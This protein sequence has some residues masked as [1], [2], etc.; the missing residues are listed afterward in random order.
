MCIMQ[1]SLVLVIS[2]RGRKMTELKRRKDS[3]NR[4]LKQNESQR[5]DGT[6]QYRWRD[7]LGNRFT[8]YAKT[9]QELREKEEQLTQAKYDGIKVEASKTTLND[10]Y[11][12]WVTLKR[13]LKDNTFQNYQY[14]Y[15][16]FV[17]ADF[18]KYKVTEIK[19]SDVRR[20]YNQLLDI[21]NVKVRTIEN[22]QTVLYQVFEL[23]IEE[24]YIRVNPSSN[25]LRELKRVHGDDSEKRKALTL[26]EQELFVKFLNEDKICER[27]KN[28][29][30]V[31]LNTGLRVGEL[32]GLRWEDVDFENN[33]ISVNHTLVYYNHRVNGCY[34]S[35]NTPKTKAG[36]RTVPM[37]DIVKEALLNECKLQR[38]SGIPQNIMIDGYTGFIFLNRYGNVNNQAMLN[39]ALKYIIR[40]CNEQ[41]LGNISN[42]EKLV[43]LPK[44]SCHTLR[45][46]FATRLIEAGVNIKVIQETLGHTDIKT[47]LNIYADATEDLKSKEFYKLNDYLKEQNTVV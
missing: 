28:I 35:V 3:K 43:L 24:N 31:M 26:K 2:E 25:A 17:K 44:F 1:L 11:G 39:K 37:I 45:H 8:I 34:F 46:T 47:T 10:I 21:R 22:I 15:E 20:F 30:T 6:Y 14:M 9:L 29:F 7:K 23:A 36:Y 38:E 5:K 33:T 42:T 32:T 40:E 41:I 16:A 18:G 13:G 4:V 12:L 19:K 27:W